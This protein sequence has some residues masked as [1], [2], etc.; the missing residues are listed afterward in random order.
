MRIEEYFVIINKTA[1]SCGSSFL[2]AFD[3]CFKSFVVFYLPPA[4]ESY[5]QWLFI[6]HGVAGKPTILPVPPV[7]QALIGQIMPAIGSN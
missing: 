3:T 4:V 7:V 6:Q 1:I 2:V 5:N